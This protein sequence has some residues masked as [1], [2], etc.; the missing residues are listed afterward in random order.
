MTKLLEVGPLELEVLGLLNSAG[1]QSVGA[2]QE[3]LKKSGHDLAYTTVMTVLVRLHN[4]NLVT[5]QKDGRLFLYSPAKKKESSA[6]K[7]FE[8]VKNSLFRTE[9][10]A[11]ILSLLEG[12]DELTKEELQSLKK[13][14]EERLKR[15]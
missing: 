13:A 1:E 9:R 4:K 8:K 10:L 15:K 2:I 6:N 7:I 3:G 14:V 5:R 12:E 11:P